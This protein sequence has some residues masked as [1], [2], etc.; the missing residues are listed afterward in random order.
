MIAVHQIVTPAH[1]I[2]NLLLGSR[3]PT[4]YGEASQRGASPKRADRSLSPRPPRASQPGRCWPQ[5]GRP[6]LSSLAAYGEV[7][8][9]SVDPQGAGLPLRPR[10]IWATEGSAVAKAKSDVVV[11]AAKAKSAV[12]TLASKSKTARDLL[13]AFG[14]CKKSLAHRPQPSTSRA[15]RPQNTRRTSQRKTTAGRP[16][17]WGSKFG[18]Q[19]GQPCLPRST[20]SMLF[21]AEV[22]RKDAEAEAQRLKINAKADNGGA[23]PVSA[24]IDEDDELLDLKD[25]LAA[26]NLKDSPDNNGVTAVEAAKNAPKNK[27]KVMI[28]DSD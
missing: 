14:A 26:Y 6:P 4:A 20:S 10:T 11:L 19:T 5:R 15:H 13:R 16:R 21:A 28:V 7:G 25:R 3:A 8:R 17:S 18:E 27:K 12:D 22:E 2:V 9:G 1:G 23:K 24:E